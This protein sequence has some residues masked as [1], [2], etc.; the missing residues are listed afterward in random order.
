MSKKNIALILLLLGLGV[1][2]VVYF[3][4]S[5]HGPIIQ[6]SA[7]PR[8]ERSRRSGSE[9]FSVSFS[10]DQ[11][12]KLTEVRTVAVDE[13]ATNKYAH[14]L[15][16]VVADTNS[17]PLKGVVYGETPKG[18]KSKIPKVR[19]EPLQSEIKYRLFVE[20]DGRKGQ[21]DFEIP[22]GRT[23]ATPEISKKRTR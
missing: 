4:D 23:T 11:K 14:V 12:C 22:K 13:I 19:A 10:F 9:V 8:I 5:F 15:W 18:M 17:T 7:R 16:H 6:I 2:Y 3:T 21:V 20:A 1:I